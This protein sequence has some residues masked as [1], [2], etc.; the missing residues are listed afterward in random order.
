MPLN[1]TAKKSLRIYTL[2]MAF[3]FITTKKYLIPEYPNK[4]IQKHYEE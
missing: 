3:F 4:P 1:N 2:K